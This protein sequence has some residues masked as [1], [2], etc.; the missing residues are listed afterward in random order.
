M[1]ELWLPLSRVRFHK[2]T[3]FL[4]TARQVVFR[5]PVDAIFDIDEFAP[6]IRIEI[7]GYQDSC[8]LG[9][10]NNLE[11]VEAAP[12]PVR[13]TYDEQIDVFF[14]S[15]DSGRI[16]TQLTDNATVLLDEARKFVG[17]AVPNNVVDYVF[18]E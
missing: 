15:V 8:G 1:I 5:V 12:R 16:R 11:F 13:L 3:Q 17:L 6:L 2:E 9:T 10:L 18:L 7:V 14:L 4:V